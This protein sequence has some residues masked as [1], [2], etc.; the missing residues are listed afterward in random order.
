[1][2]TR[3]IVILGNIPLIHPDQRESLHSVRLSDDIRMPDQIV[4]HG[5]AYAP[6]SSNE[7]N[8]SAFRK[9][10]AQ[11]DIYRGDKEGII[12]T[13]G[14]VH[15]NKINAISHILYQELKTQLHSKKRILVSKSADAQLHVNIMG[16]GYLSTGLGFGKK[17]GPSIM[18]MVTITKNQKVIWQSGAG[19]SPVDAEPSY[20]VAELSQNPQLVLAQWKQAI[21]IA[22]DKLMV[23]MN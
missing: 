5:A 18:F 1:M 20:T 17:L 23:K 16:Y 19:V 2:A 8:R 3:P 10:L 4:V 11:Y 15:N 12:D 7:S 9:A 21:K 6:I 13:W 14:F 22:V